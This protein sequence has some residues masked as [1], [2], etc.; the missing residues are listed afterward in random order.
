MFDDSSHMLKSDVELLLISFFSC[1]EL[2]FQRDSDS[3]EHSFHHFLV[4]REINFQKKFS[5]ANLP[6]IP[7]NIIIS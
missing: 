2:L 4:P 5:E 7:R 3:L 6:F 1:L